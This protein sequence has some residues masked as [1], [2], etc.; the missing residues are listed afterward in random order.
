MIKKIKSVH[1]SERRVTKESVSS[2]Y[3]LHRANRLI[4]MLLAKRFISKSEYDQ[5]VYLNVKAYAPYL[6]SLYEIVDN[7]SL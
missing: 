3:N 7:Q 6:L 4:N 2:T 1:Y 5:L